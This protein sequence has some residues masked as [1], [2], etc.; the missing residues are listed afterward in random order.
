[1]VPRMMSTGPSPFRPQPALLPT[2]EIVAALK[3]A[4]TL[5]DIY[6]LPFPAVAPILHDDDTLNDFTAS[7]GRG[8]FR[9]DT[10]IDA[11]GIEINDSKF[12]Q[13]PTLHDAIHT[14]TDFDTVSGKNLSNRKIEFELRD[15]NVSGNHMAVQRPHCDGVVMPRMRIGFYATARPTFIVAHDAMTQLLNTT[16]PRLLD[17]PF[18]DPSFY[19]DFAENCMDLSGAFI[20]AAQ[21]MREREYTMLTGV[22][23][24]FMPSGPVGDRRFLRT[25]AYEIAP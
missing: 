23:P 11:N 22:T 5:R 25:R 12:P 15:P 8:S 17:T 18:D 7:S 9:T 6:R 1:M 21:P 4:K 10:I 13:E 20:R 2:H 14:V 19:R 24:H 3:D 16:S